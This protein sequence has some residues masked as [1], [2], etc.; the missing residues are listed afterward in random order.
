[1]SRLKPRPTKTLGL[2]RW[3]T[4]AGPSRLWASKMPAVPNRGPQRLLGFHAGRRKPAL[5]GS[6]QARCRRHK[7]EAGKM[8]A[9]QKRS[10]QDA[11]G[12]KAEPAGCRRYKSGAGK[13]PMVQ[14]RSRQDADGTKAEPAGCRRYKS[15]AGRMPAVQNPDPEGFIA[16]GGAR[17]EGRFPGPRRRHW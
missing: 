9:V 10:R 3:A 13:M 16:G 5:R 1:M 11:G 12:T 4:E 7:S 15:G 2:S 14:K 8:P 17:A 6:G